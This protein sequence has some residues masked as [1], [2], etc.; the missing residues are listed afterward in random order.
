MVGAWVG[1]EYRSIHFRTGALGQGSRT[2]LPIVGLFLH[3][4]MDDPAFQKYH[5]RFKKPTADDGI[6]SDMYVCQS[7]QPR[8]VR[9]TTR[10]DSSRV[11]SDQEV[12][13]DENGEPIE[14]LSS[15]EGNHSAES[16]SSKANETQKSSKKDKSEKEINFNDL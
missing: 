9:D 2:A 14:N 1:G 15:E 11:I 7:Y 6:T 12:F 10:V 8:V 3:Y 16:K 13:L 4:V 5:G